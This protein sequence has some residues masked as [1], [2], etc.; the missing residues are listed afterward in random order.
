MRKIVQITTGGNE[1]EELF[2]LCDD[3]TLW[4]T[5]SP[6]VGEDSKYHLWY[7]VIPIPQDN[8]DKKET[9]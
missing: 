3:G 2:A 7:S 4:Q 9:A 1:N 5:S 8:D 6:F